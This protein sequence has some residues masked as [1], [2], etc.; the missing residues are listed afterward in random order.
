MKYVVIDLEMCYVPK[1]TADRCGCRM[2]IIQIGA[3]QMNGQFQI[4]NKFNTYVKPQFGYI[5]TFIHKL[6]GIANKNIA[7]AQNLN[8]ALKDFRS[9]LPKEE[10][11]VV[12]WSL[13]DLDQLREEMRIKGIGTSETDRIADRWIDA[14]AMFNEKMRSQ[15]PFALSDALFIADIDT[16]GSAH[17]GLADAYNTAVLFARMM[18][19]TLKINDYYIN[20]KR[21]SSTLGYTLAD[22]LGNIALTA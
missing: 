18:Q 19:N 9:W 1:E 8:D 6:T 7:G 14:Q 10:F 3:V 17:D 13:T 16:V 21:D 11:R 20:A 4:T 2:E 22:M 12:S 5:N 15:S